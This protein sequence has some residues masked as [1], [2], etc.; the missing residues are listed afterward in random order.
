[1]ANYAWTRGQP[2]PT[3]KDGHVFEHANFTQMK[4]HTKIFVG[5][6]GL[7]FRDCNLLNCDVP[8]DAIVEDCMLGHV[9]YCGHEHPDWVERGKLEACPVDCQHVVD[10]DEIIIDGILLDRITHYRDKVIL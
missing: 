2:L 10:A 1:M 4:P 5:V 6:K 8:E 3:V 9:S 7:V